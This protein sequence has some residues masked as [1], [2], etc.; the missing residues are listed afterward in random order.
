VT[1]VPGAAAPESQGPPRLRKSCAQPGRCGC[2]CAVLARPPASSP[3]GSPLPLPDT[4]KGKGQKSDPTDASLTRP[5][6]KLRRFVAELSPPSSSREGCVRERRKREKGRRKERGTL[7][8]RYESQV[9]YFRGYVV[10]LDVRDNN[11]SRED[12]IASGR[13]VGL[14]AR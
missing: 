10:Q 13:S 3:P 2:A 7:S 5:F 4:H 1:V 12:E 14:I 8:S 6:W 9:T 11:W